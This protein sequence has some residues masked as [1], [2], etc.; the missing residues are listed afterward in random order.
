M[1]KRT[2][3]IS[4]IKSI[5]T[6]PAIWETVA[7]DSQNPNLWEPDL[8]GSCWLQVTSDSILT[9]LWQFRPTNAITLEVHPYILPEYRGKL[10]KAA[11]VDHLQWFYFY[12]PQ[13][14]KLVA[15]IPTIYRHVKLFGNM[16]G[17]QNE[18]INRASYRKNGVIYDQWNIGITR[19]EIERRFSWAA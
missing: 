6:V 4:L 16:L 18:G 9:G 19:K 17:Y 8:L 3:D 10:G 14:H 12:C 13:Y 11:G 7:E 15:Q 2:Y 1:I 5:V